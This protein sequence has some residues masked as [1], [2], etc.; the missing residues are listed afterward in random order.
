V[1]TI[2]RD[3]AICTKARFSRWL[4]FRVFQQYRRKAAVRDDGHS[5]AA[6]R[7]QLTGALVTIDAIGTQTDIAERIVTGGGD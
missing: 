1:R 7:L 4:N 6:E 2:G 3:N 5:A